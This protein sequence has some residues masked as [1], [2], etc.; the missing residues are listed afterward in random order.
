L[1]RSFF[2]LDKK[3]ILTANCN[4]ENVIKQLP[5][6]CAVIVRQY[7]M[8]KQER[9]KFAKSIIKIA[10]PLGI[11]ILIGKDF[12]LAKKVKADGVHFSDFDILPFNFLREKRYLKKFIFS[13]SCHSL[14]SFLKS[15]IFQP[16]VVFISPIFPTTSHINAKTLGIKNLAKITLKTKSGT[17]CKTSICPLGGIDK[18]NII[19]IRKLKK[20]SGFG[21]ISLFLE[22]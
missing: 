11:K 5:N 21:A 22:N 12:Y 10:R 19:S 2:F 1:P 8:E 4:L 7:D 18:D 9:E 13:F 15:Q 20:I 3:K 17:Y 16:D 6:D 14:K